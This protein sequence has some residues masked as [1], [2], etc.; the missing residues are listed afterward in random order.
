MM[1]KVIKFVA[2]PVVWITGLVISMIIGI[3][4]GIGAFIDYKNK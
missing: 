4:A 1:K 3:F 2:K